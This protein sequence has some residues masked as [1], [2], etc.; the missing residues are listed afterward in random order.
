M[1]ASQIDHITITAP[2][3]E[4]GAAAI[5]RTLGVMPQAGGEHPRMGTHNLL[6]RLG[7]AAFLEVISPNP[8]A[9]APQRP[10][11]FALDELRSD[12]PPMLATWVVRT[13]DIYRTASACT[14]PLGRIEPMR[15]GSLDWLITI[16]E[17]G[18][19]PVDGI[20]PALIEWQTKKHPASGLQDHGLGL[21]RLEL[22][23][24]DP[25]RIAGLLQ[26]VVL[27]CPVT[28]LPLRD[29]RRPYIVAHIDTPQGLRVLSG[30]EK[31]GSGQAS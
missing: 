8:D 10:R 6:L 1:P 19:L 22:F 13:D 12:S 3:L 23:H 16:P 9:P 26:S 7:D 28:V 5:L 20:G 15:R 17:N 30:A 14:E 24:A 18:G 4:S 11:W 2:T 31:Q 29:A 21:A 27:E 25:Q